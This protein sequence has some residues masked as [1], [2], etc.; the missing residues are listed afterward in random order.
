MQRVADAFGVAP[1]LVREIEFVND[2]LGWHESP[3]KRFQ[4]V[5]KW[6][7]EQLAGKAEQR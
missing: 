1:A 3:E 2:E 5:R 7:V 4:I 6:C